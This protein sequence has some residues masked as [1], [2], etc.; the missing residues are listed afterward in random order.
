MWYN[1][2]EYITVTGPYWTAHDVKVIFF[3][4][5]FSS[6][7]IIEQRFNV[8][9]NKVKS[10]IGYDIIIG[11]DLMVQL[12]LLNDFERQ[13]IQ[14]HFITVSMKEPIGLLGKSCLTSHEMCEVVVQTKETAFKRE[15]TERVVKIL[16]NTYENA[17][18]KQVADKATQQ[19]AEKRTQ[20][21][22]IL[23]YFENLFDGTLGEWDT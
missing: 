10:G 1:K 16:Y 4:Q 21:L 5:E 2:V 23:E 15:A 11:S 14:W 3:I 12:F 9:N 17:D 18:L 20:L 8:D 7:K 13:V 19:N 6:S 22:R